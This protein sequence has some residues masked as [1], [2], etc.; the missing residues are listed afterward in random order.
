M[1][2]E[3]KAR[4]TIKYERDRILDTVSSVVEMGPILREH[5][6]QLRTEM[7]RSSARAQMILDIE[8]DTFS[9]LAN[10][11]R[12]LLHICGSAIMTIGNNT[13]Q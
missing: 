1:L 13:Q 10:D 8:Y 12:E 9:D 4:E 6:N 11:A 3:Q 2:N 7:L 5:A